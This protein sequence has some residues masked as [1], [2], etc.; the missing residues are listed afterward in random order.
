MRTGRNLLARIGLVILVAF[1]LYRTVSSIVETGIVRLDDFGSDQ[2]AIYQ[3]RFDCLKDTLRHHP[4]SGYTD[5]SGWFKA[6]YALAPTILVQGY[7]QAVVVANFNQDSSE[8]RSRAEA[9][10]LLL[11]DCLN[12]VRLYQGRSD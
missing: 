7:D 10:L 11:H 4:I 1:V 2:F 9:E 12:G 8:N 6:Q 3:T 5:D